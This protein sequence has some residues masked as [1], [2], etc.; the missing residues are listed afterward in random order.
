[1][2]DKKISNIVLEN[3]R[4]IFKNFAGEEKKYNPRGKRNFC[5]IIPNNE[6]ANA[7]ENDGWNIKWL[8]PRD[9]DDEPTPYIQ[10]AVAFGSYPPNITLISSKGKK[11]RLD[12]DTV[13]M[14]DTAEI[15]NVDVEIRP[16]SWEANGKT[17]IKA[18]VK[19]MYVTIE[20]DRLAAKYDN[21]DDDNIP[22]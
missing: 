1:M 3:A 18:Y 6:V 2:D 5:V 22:F 4:I 17:G 16:Y 9:E 7:L 19:N 21:L 13:S 12:E 14:L 15:T 8:Q 11:T 20:E 10:V